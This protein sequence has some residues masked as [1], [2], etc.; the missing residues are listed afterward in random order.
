MH[1]IVYDYKNEKNVKKIS[2]TFKSNFIFYHVVPFLFYFQRLKSYI[3]LLVFFFVC[4][5]KTCLV[6]NM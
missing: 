6:A 5:F 1:D 2:K 4:F 3:S